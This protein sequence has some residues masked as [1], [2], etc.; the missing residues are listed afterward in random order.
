MFEL[1]DCPD[2]S[3]PTET[4]EE[5]MCFALTKDIST[6]MN[7]GWERSPT[8]W[9]AVMR[10]K[11]DH[12]LDDPEFEC[13]EGAAYLGAVMTEGRH[14][15]ELTPRHADFGDCFGGSPLWAGVVNPSRY[16]LDDYHSYDNNPEPHDANNEPGVTL[17]PNGA[18]NPDDP[19]WLFRFEANLIPRAM[20][21]STL[22]AVAS[23][24]DHAISK[25]TQST[26]SL[27]LLLDLECGSLEV[28]L[29]GAPMGLLVKS[30][31]QAPLRWAIDLQPC[32]PELELTATYSC[33]ND[34]WWADLFEQ[35]YNLLHGA[36]HAVFDTD[37]G[38]Q[39]IIKAAD[40]GVACAEAVCTVW[41]WAGRTKSDKNDV[42]QAF[43]QL[44]DEPDERHRTQAMYYAGWLNTFGAG[45]HDMEKAVEWLIKGTERGDSQAMWWLGEMHKND[46]PFGVGR[47]PHTTKHWFVE[48][49]KHGHFSSKEDLAYMQEDF[50][51]LF[52]ET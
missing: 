17:G 46:P 13:L 2:P 3:Q 34:M 24:H 39:L 32:Y 7:F 36:N 11:G 33:L 41:E 43:E 18:A 22:A 44:A 49:D 29:D 10:M 45:G 14:F 37:R 4:P 28:H 5:Q 30:G 20:S 51:E 48:A 40:M 38:E 6:Y 47:D 35:G 26:G 21:R 15:L 16:S 9:T 8:G 42:L 1:G 12:D 31:I 19:G 25:P 50:P 27:G 23:V 52:E